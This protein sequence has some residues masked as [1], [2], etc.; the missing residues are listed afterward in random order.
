MVDAGDSCRTSSRSSIYNVPITSILNLSSSFCWYA[1]C[2]LFHLKETICWYEQ[3]I[4]S[5]T[6]K[7]KVGTISRNVAFRMKPTCIQ[8][9]KASLSKL[10]QSLIFAFCR[11][12]RG[13]Y[14]GSSRTSPTYHF[15]HS[16]TPAIS[17]A[18]H[19]TCL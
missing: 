17:F 18:I 15:V 13:S 10:N 3:S 19:V 4:I 14:A 1:P 8:W 12:R 9:Y 2:T 16:K 6:I 5:K 7:W 11:M